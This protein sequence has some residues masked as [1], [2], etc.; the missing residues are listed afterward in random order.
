ML[1][2][3][4][5]IF[6]RVADAFADMDSDAAYVSHRMRLPDFVRCGNQLSGWQNTPSCQP[7]K[8]TKAG[9]N[10]AIMN[11]QY[12]LYVNSLDVSARDWY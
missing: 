9:C 3:F 6:Q 5:N 8:P 1:T 11:C 7:A 12:S 10:A 4:D 2:N